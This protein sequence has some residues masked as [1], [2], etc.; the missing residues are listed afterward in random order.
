MHTRPSAESP[1]S[2]LSRLWHTEATFRSAF[3]D[4]AIGMAMLGTDGKFLKVNR[5]LCDL[6]GY[7]AA[8]LVGRRFAEIT[9]PDDRL[10]DERPVARMMAGGDPHVPAGEAVLA[11]GRP[12]GV[13][14]GQRLPGP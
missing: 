12:R 7:D 10:G 2:R 13:G 8:E 9:H 3:D 11:Q 4:A 6:V 1:T 5:P 14:A